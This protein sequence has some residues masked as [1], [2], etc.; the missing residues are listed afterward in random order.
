MSTSAHVKND[1]VPSSPQQIIDAIPLT[2]VHPQHSP[3]EE[4]RT[5]KKGDSSQ[6]SKKSSPFAKK[7]I[8]K[9]K[10]SKS[11]KSHTM[12][13]LY[14]DDTTT[15]NVT[16]KGATPVIETT[17][18]GV[19]SPIQVSEIL[20]KDNPNYV[21]TLGV[22][23]PMFSENLGKNVLNATTVVDSSVDD[24]TKGSKDC[25]D[26]NLK[27]TIPETTVVPSIGTFVAPATATSVGT[28]GIPETVH[29]TATEK[30]GTPLVAKS[31]NNLVDY[32]ESD[33]SNKTL[34]EEKEA[35]DPE[36]VIMSD[37]VTGDKHVT[38]VSDAGIARRTRSR[39]GKDGTTASTLVH[40]SKPDK[41]AK[42]FGKKVVT[43]PPRAKRS[44]KGRKVPV[45]VPYV[46]LDNVSFHLENGPTRWKYVYHRRLA[47]ERNLK[48]D[49][50]KCKNIADVLTHA[51]L[52]RTVSDLG[53]YY[54]KLVREFMVNV[55]DNCDD[56]Q[57]P[58]YRQVF[59]R[60]KCVH[61]SPS[62]INKFLGRSDEEVAELEV[63]DNDICRR[64]TRNRLKQ[65]PSQ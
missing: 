11:S 3:M 44:V 56:P 18:K 23:N 32:S 12:S 45:A 55:A 10:K 38:K 53:D 8:V 28:S 49:V 6:V 5:K 19:E 54:D 34:T 9:G 30:V 58:E 29:Y 57:N 21:E 39:A 60:G 2:I 51:G 37:N 22:E 31:G 64:I 25:V 36:V 62:I 46:P 26:K 47:L 41:P 63:T 43:G 48:D 33:E 7:S 13:E 24:P 20:G 52:M 40:K 35:S 14:L 59:V 4:Q 65:W 50:L 17:S 15:E 61:F 42:L 16:S 1:D 27:E